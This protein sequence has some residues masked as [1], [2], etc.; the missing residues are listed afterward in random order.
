VKGKQVEFVPFANVKTG[1]GI[2]Y[3]NFLAGVQ[4]TYY[5]DQFTDASNKVVASNDNDT[6]VF[7]KI[8]SFYVADLSLSYKWK[9]WKL[10]TGI[11]NFT[12]HY[13]FTRRATGYPGPGIIPS[14]PRTFYATLE[15]SF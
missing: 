9:M 11:N 4:F 10:E 2:G 6:G 5:S 7:G 14:D 8:P 1:T 13:Y 15:F 12:N 3:R